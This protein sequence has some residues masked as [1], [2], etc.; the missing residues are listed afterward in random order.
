[1]PERDRLNA[2]TDGQGFVRTGRVCGSLTLPRPNP[3]RSNMQANRR[4]D[5]KPELKVRQILFARGLRYFVD[6]RPIKDVRWKADIVFPRAQVVVFIDGCYWHGCPD[7]YS[8]PR[9]NTGYWAPK[10]AG[11]QERDRK[12]DEILGARGWTVVR[13]WEHEDP[14]QV[15]DRVETVVRSTQSGQAQQRGASSRGRG[16]DAQRRPR[17]G[18]DPL[19]L[20]TP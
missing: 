17:D 10:I 12:F 11:N 3:R 9:V 5:T 7:H 4:R 20:E 8:T 1:M 19:D 14:I 16:P 2:P 18:G 15:A 13:A 6:R